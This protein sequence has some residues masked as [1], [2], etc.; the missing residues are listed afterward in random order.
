MRAVLALSLVAIVVGLN[1]CAA[2]PVAALGAGLFNAGASA[3]MRAGTEIT[4]GGVVYKT[5]TLPLDELRTAVGNTLAQMELAVVND[6][7]E[8]DGD[9]FIVARARDREIEVTLE[10]V[11]RTVTRVRLVVSE[12][13][14]GRDRA[15]AAEIM[16]QTE[17]TVEN[18]AFTRGERGIAASSPARGARR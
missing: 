1:G 14:F 9:R 11:T 3:A 13:H 7:V 12:G 15:T 16:A 5:F 18:R 2:L 17:K 10:P 4:R 8:Q 6:H